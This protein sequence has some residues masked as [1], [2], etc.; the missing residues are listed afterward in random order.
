M[1]NEVKQY[2]QYQIS[3]SENIL[4]IVVVTVKGEKNLYSFT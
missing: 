2:S 4:F 3:H 1:I